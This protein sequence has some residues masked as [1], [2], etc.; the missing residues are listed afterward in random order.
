MEHRILAGL[1]PGLAIASEEA[2]AAE[3]ARLEAT[4]PGFLD[5]RIAELK[6]TDPDVARRILELNER[7]A[8][9]GDGRVTQ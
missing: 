2:T 9:A 8:S 4:D 5:R 7:E 1:K 3:L 6:A